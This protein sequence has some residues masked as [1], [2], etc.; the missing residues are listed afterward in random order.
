MPNG[1]RSYYPIP[2]NIYP[3]DYICVTLKIPNDEAYVSAFVGAFYGLTRWFNHERDDDHNGKKVADVWLGLYNDLLEVIGNQTCDNGDFPMLRQNPLNPCQMEYQDNLGNWVV[4]FDYSLCEA[5]GQNIEIGALLNYS[6]TNIAIGAMNDE[7]NTYN[8]DP[9][10]YDPQEAVNQAQIDNRN[11][12]LC[13]ALRVI[14][15]STL[16]TIARNKEEAERN[17]ITLAM[18]VGGVLALGFAPLSPIVIGSI[19]GA[20]G[21]GYTVAIQSV[22]ENELRDQTATD[23]VLCHLYFQLSDDNLSRSAVQASVASNPF[24]DGT[25]EYKQFA[26]IKPMFE[27]LEMY[28]AIINHMKENIASVQA[29]VNE[30]LD[31]G[32]ETE[33]S[34][35]F[36]FT[37]SSH[38]AWWT[39]QPFNVQQMAYV[40]GTG[41]N[42]GINIPSGNIRYIVNYLRSIVWAQNTFVHGYDVYYTFVATTVG[43]NVET[44][45]Q[46]VTELD[47]VSSAITE[48]DIASTS[49]TAV[50][51]KSLEKIVDRIKFQIVGGR[52]SGANPNGQI[53]VTKIVITGKGYNPFA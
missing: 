5:F 30:C 29:L 50:V 20:F 53:T 47:G 27:T 6:E 18:I 14:V 15:S 7:K 28:L 49:H 23:K 36:D 44:R 32:D 2:A 9:N 46:W 45:I 38:S 25:P 33:W 12:L 43:D 24:S 52:R 22:N 3:E 35:E 39:A 34:H 40:A 51:Y 21:V 26:V 19:L 13:Y 1:K 41:W 11:T 17:Q 8:Q 42:A 31:C 10:G 16:E 48:T 4:F 37:V